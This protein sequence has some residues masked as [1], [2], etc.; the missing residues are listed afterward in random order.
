ML[1]E[2]STDVLSV[3]FSPDGRTLAS[4]GGVVLPFLGCGEGEAQTFKEYTEFFSNRSIV[5]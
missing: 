5:L 1:R 3:S 4:G 2:H